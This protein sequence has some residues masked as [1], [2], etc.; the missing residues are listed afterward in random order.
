MPSLLVTFAGQSIAHYPIAGPRTRI[1]RRPDNDIVLNSLAVSGEHAALVMDGGR[2][3]IEDLGSRNG[4]Y[5]GGARID[6]QELDHAGVVRIGEYTLT[7]I[8]DKAAMAYEATMMVRS[9]PV[10]QAARLHCIEGPRAG[11]VLALTKVVTTLGKPGICVVTCI[12][13]GDE[14]AV[15]F[16]EG[17]TAARLNGAV[18]GLD[19][20][21]LKA[22]DV[23]ELVGSKLQFRLSAA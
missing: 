18:L 8:A 13:R 20:V 16:T 12:R 23:L 10:A 15:R 19:P 2:L 5:I 7:L 9:A 11:E 3:A 17:A 14:F 4:T 1:G 22:G 21:R 6:R